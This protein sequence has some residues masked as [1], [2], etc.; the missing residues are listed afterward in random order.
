MGKHAEH[1]QLV[2]PRH[3]DARDSTESLRSEIG[4]GKQSRTEV[5]VQSPH[6]LGAHP[7]FTRGFE[8]IEAQIVAP[9]PPRHRRMEL[10][11]CAAC[12]GYIPATASKSDG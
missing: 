9:F 10:N 2:D 4:R 11:R 7:A 8:G 3:P 1:R 6:Q 12:G 5:G